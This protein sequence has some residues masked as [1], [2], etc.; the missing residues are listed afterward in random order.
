MPSQPGWFSQGFTPDENKDAELEWLLC[1]AS[2]LKA[3]QR[4]REAAGRSEASSEPLGQVADTA[5]THAAPPNLFIA[6]RRL[7]LLPKRPKGSSA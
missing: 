1:L 5:A 6:L 4:V 3:S 7:H 2:A